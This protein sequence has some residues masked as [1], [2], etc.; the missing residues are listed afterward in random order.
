MFKRKQ[1]NQCGWELKLF[2]KQKFC[3]NDCAST[4]DRNKREYEEHKNRNK[5]K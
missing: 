1:C 4:Y 3:S 2:E 5:N